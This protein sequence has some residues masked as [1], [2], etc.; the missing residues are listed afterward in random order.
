MPK[1]YDYEIAKVS[2]KMIEEMF[3]V[4]P[5]EV[6]AITAD[7]GS[8][9]Q[10]IEAIANAVYAAGGKPL[11]MWVA[12]ARTNGQAGVI[13]W[14]SK[15]L[16]AALCNVDVW[17]EAQ[18]VC[19]LY[20][21]IF[22]EAFA[23]NK[24]LRYLIVGD[25]TIKELI[26]LVGGCNV[27]KLG[28]LLRPIVEILNDVKEIRV[29]NDRGTDVTFEMDQNFVIDVDYGDYSM[30]KFGTMPGYVN[31]IPKFGS[32]NGRI[33][34]DEIS[35]VGIVGDELV[36]FVMKDSKIVEFNGGQK[37]KRIEKI[38]ESFDDENLYKV[39][40]MMLSLHPAIRELSG[41]I[42]ADERIWGGVD[43]GFGHVSPLDAPPHGQPS[44]SHID[45]ILRD[46]TIYF[47]GVKI[48][49][50]GIFQHPE[51]KK[52]AEDLMQ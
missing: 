34:F 17:I 36:E 47:D 32:M 50:K 2:K 16:T 38:F 31:V 24:K 45:G 4:K 42:V 41:S 19:M 3:K 21:E 12:A 51:L 46:V 37:A 8:D 43:F 52:Y 39:A 26:S 20:S 1:V 7:S 27:E 44:K 28:K 22:E 49:E 35:S 9:E 18:S 5:G 33:V 29:T 23:A 6:V 25:A 15:A 13:D 10:I 48:I 30:P 14:P 40:H 11:T